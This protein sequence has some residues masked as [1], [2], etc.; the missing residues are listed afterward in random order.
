MLTLVAT[1]MYQNAPSPYRLA[2]IDIDDTLTGPDKRV[3]PA[4]RA[5]VR[6]LAAAGCRVVLASGRRHGNM[7]RYA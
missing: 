4:N 2:A 7:L 3:G 1:L 6:R 5:A